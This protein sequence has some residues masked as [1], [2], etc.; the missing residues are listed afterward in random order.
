ML[1]KIIIFIPAIENGGVERNAI[2]VSNELIKKGYSVDFIYVRSNSDRLSQLSEEVNIIKLNSKKI[3]FLHE[4]LNDA[5]FAFI[6][7]RKYLKVI[8][9]SESVVLSFQSSIVSIIVS[10]MLGV[11]IV[12]RLSNHPS[13]AKH[14]KS[15]L[16]K[17]SEYLKPLF[18]RKADAII[19]V[20][21]KLSDDFSKSVKRNVFTIYN[22]FDFKKVEIL[23]NEPIEDEICFD[24]GKP[25]IISI[26]RLA[27]QKDFLTL[28][29]GFSLSQK[30]INTNLWIIGEGEERE[31]IEAYIQKE[32]LTSK[33]KL[34]GFKKNVYKYLRYGD[35]FI[36][37]PL[38]EGI[39]N[40]LI[41]AIAA[42]LPA[43]STDCLSGPREI[44]LDG[45]GGELIPVG[46]EVELSNKII[47]F[48]KFPE[49][50]KGKYEIAQQ[51]L[52]RFDNNVIIDKYI[53]VLSNVANE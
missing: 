31:K 7:F 36:Q 10:K 46:G 43:I 34:L 49:I 2:W 30:S 1:S 48:F 20:S 24:N 32:G 21:K 12:C 25:L 53:E 44:L 17:L 6:G 14:E 42:G 50:Q 40:V 35:L 45:K 9:K 38:Y 23:K 4:R 26:G 22:P 5:I 16:R 52:S 11:K 47:E 37:T 18:Y 19:S 29:K 39:G 3:S 13:S 41:E 15:L 8:N 51:H 27:K 28:L 33:V